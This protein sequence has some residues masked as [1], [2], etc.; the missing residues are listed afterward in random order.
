[1]RF[2]TKH[3]RL[4]VSDWVLLVLLRIIVEFLH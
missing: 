4:T 3:L 2:E 1:M